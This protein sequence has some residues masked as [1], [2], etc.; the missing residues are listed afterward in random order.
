MSPSQSSNFGEY[1]IMITQSTGLHLFLL[2]SVT[3]SNVADF[4][5]CLESGSIISPPIY[6]KRNG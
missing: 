4:R 2:I 3:Y 1:D 6:L 5:S